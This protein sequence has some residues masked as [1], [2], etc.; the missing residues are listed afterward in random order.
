MAQITDILSTLDELLRPGDFDD[1]GPNG[2]Q[3]PGA[4]EIT[5]VVTGVTARR[6]L[7]ERAVELGAELVLV[8]H[9][10]FWKFHPTGLT[11]LLAERLRPLFKHDINL[12]AY[13]LPLDA[14][15]EVGNNA[16][17]VKQLGCVDREPF[18]SYKGRP[19]GSR[20]RFP[21]PITPDELAARVSTVTGREPL[22]LGQRD[23]VISTIGIVSGSAADT[24]HEAAALGLDAFLTGEPREH[25]TADAEELGISF[26]AA[27]H[28]ATEIFG[29]R[30][31]GDLLADRFG[32][33]HVFVDLSNPV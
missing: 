18:G 24:L 6:E 3:V 12:A 20:G 4:T 7:H 15:P 28:Y 25:I 32:V 30:A 27:G 23:Q 22:L 8:H 26:V 1:L 10:L 13:H 31:L 11:P 16:L 21:E 29:V 14:H 2:L 19:I 9:G 5:R 17:L 33:E